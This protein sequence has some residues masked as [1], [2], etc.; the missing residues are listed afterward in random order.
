MNDNYVDETLSLHEDHSDVK[1][2]NF[3]EEKHESSVFVE[4]EFKA[5][6]ETSFCGIEFKSGQL[7][8]RT[9]FVMCY[10]F[11]LCDHSVL[12]KSRSFKHKNGIIKT[13]QEMCRACLDENKKGRKLPDFKIST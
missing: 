13:K 1:Q 5:S 10:L 9:S 6:V 8:T 4:G 7:W 3:K 11:W 12:T 2:Q